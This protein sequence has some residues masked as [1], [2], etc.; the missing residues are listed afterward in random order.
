MRVSTVVIGR[1]G[2]QFAVGGGMGALNLAAQLPA[3]SNIG[4]GRGRGKRGKEGRVGLWAHAWSS[5]CPQPATATSSLCGYPYVLICTGQQCVF[6]CPQEN[7]SA[8]TG[9]SPALPELQ[10]FKGLT[11]PAAT[12]YTMFWTSLACMYA[13]MFSTTAS[14]GSCKPVHISAAP[15]DPPAS[16]LAASAASAASATL[17]PLPPAPAGLVTPS[18]CPRSWQSTPTSSHKCVGITPLY[19]HTIEHKKSCP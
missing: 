15:A 9:L 11:F 1:Q 13:C 6:P 18:S 2:L 12:T 19:H 8:S 17:P 16:L 10:V 14:A 4:A 3:N 5:P 7:T